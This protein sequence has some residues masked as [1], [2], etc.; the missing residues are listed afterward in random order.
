MTQTGRMAYIAQPLDLSVISN[1]I[2]ILLRAQAEKK[3]IRIFS[4]INFGTT[5]M[6]DENMV[7]TIFRNLISN[8]IKFTPDNGQIRIF[9]KELPTNSQKPEMIQV[10]IVDSGI[11]ISP[12]TLPKLFR[13]DEKSRT[14][15]TAKERGTG[16]GLILSKELVVKN[17][18]KIWVESE[19]NKG[20]QFC[21]TLPLIR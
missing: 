11:G 10:C 6:A 8:A 2:V 14:P 1:E 15:G 13:I 4:A 7:K 17:G 20:S 9:S 5:V 18:G 19:L 16:L 12:E 21:F 3:H